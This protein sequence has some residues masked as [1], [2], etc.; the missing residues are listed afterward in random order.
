MTDESEL[1]EDELVAM[2]TEL[3]ETADLN[4]AIKLTWA[5]LD[6]TEEN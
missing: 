2:L 4:D 1:T 6:E 5:N 3:C